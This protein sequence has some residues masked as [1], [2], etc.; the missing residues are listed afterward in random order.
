MENI[1]KTLEEIKEHQMQYVQLAKTT[2][3]YK[4]ADKAQKQILNIRSERKCYTEKDIEKA[5]DKGFEDGRKKDLKGSI[6]EL[7]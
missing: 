2:E 6:I 4:L 7:L 3:V 5:Y 1:I